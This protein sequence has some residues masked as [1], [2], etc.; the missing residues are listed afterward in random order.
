MNGEEE[1]LF[2]QLF[3]WR[4]LGAAITEMHMDRFRE[5]GADPSSIFRMDIVEPGRL[6]TNDI[7]SA[8]LLVKSACG[9]DALLTGGWAVRLLCDGQVPRKSSPDL[10][11]FVQ[12]GTLTRRAEKMGL[13]P[14]S[15]WG[16]RVGFFETPSGKVRLEMNPVDVLPKHIDLIVEAEEINVAVPLVV[17]IG[18]LV[19]VTRKGSSERD[20]VD[21][22]ALLISRYG[23]ALAA[24]LERQILLDRRVKDSLVKLGFPQSVNGLF[25]GDAEIVLRDRVADLLSV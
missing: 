23:Q 11:F 8:I 21:I 13:V 7:L 15:D 1:S 16:S 2:S 25:S 20:C 5:K 4:G 18:K 10:D 17:V 3:R 24:D 19:R 9:S 6:L 14:V 12:T 22:A